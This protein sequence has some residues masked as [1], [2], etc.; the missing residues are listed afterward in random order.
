MLGIVSI[1]TWNPSPTS[2]LA[3]TFPHGLFALRFHP[4]VT[5]SMLGLLKATLFIYFSCFYGPAPAFFL[6]LVFSGVF[7]PMYT[8]IAGFVFLS[9]THF[10]FWA[11]S[12]YL[13]PHFSNETRLLD[14]G[15]DY[16]EVFS[17]SPFFIFLLLFLLFFT[18]YLT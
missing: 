5:L 2:G 3:L 8:Y 17:L 12:R 18:F 15:G 7:S 11:C 9:H 4:F 14:E 10:S 16:K 13:S 1:V 6:L